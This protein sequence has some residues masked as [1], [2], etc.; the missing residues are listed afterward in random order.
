MQTAVWVALEDGAGLALPAT[1][2]TEAWAQLPPRDD[3]G[4]A[5]LLGLPITVVIDLDAD[6]ARSVGEFMAPGGDVRVSQVAQTARVRGWPVLTA[7]PVPLRRLDAGI[8]LEELP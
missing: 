7:H 6:E 2:L 4:L 3:D 5:V 8:Q 1:A